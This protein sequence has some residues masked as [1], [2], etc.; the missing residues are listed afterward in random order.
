MYQFLWIFRIPFRRWRD[1]SKGN[2][3]ECLVRSPVAPLS[4]IAEKIAGESASCYK[5]IQRFLSKI[6]LKQILLRF[7]HEEAEFVIGDPTEMERYKA[8]KNLYMGKLSDDETTV[9]WLDVLSTPFREQA[10]PFWFVTYS[11]RTIREQATSC[12]QEHFRCFEAVK[13][14]LHAPAARLSIGQ[15]QRYAWHAD[16]QSNHKFYWEMKPPQP[17]TRSKLNIF[18]NVFSTWRRITLS[19]W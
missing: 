4:N 6:D 13:D 19:W 15:Q 8:Q 14:R 3:R 11:T 12:K 7:S 5:A 16:W 2:D 9:Y 1:G 10:I 17:S 18:R